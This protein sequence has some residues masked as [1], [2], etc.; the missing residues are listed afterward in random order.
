MARGRREGAVLTD[1]DVGCPTR[2]DVRD[3]GNNGLSTSNCAHEGE[4][5]HAKGDTADVLM[6]DCA[7]WMVEMR[8]CL[9][10]EE[11]ANAR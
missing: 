9:S 11:V 4:Y 7:T 2:R 10:K 5:M 1:Y 6:M 3:L 8:P